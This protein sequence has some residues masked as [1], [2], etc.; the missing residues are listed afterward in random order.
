M[1]I[2]RRIRNRNLVPPAKYAWII[3]GDNVNQSGGLIGTAGPS[4]APDEILSQLRVG[5]IGKRFFVQDDSGK[6]LYFGRII[7]EGGAN[8]LAEDIGGGKIKVEYAGQLQAA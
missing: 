1:N 7:G 2:V 5:G 8:E 6:T 4:N 3:W